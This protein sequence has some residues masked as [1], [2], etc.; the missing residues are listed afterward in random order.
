MNIFVLDTNPSIAAK[1]HCDKHVPKMVLELAQMLTTAHHVY[2]SEPWEGM[3][4]QA[5]L[6]HPCTKWVRENAANYTW[7]AWHFDALAEQYYHRFKKLHKTYLEQ[8]KYLVRR[9]VNM[10]HMEWRPVNMDYMRLCTPFAQAMPDEYKNED[11]A[12][13]AYRTYYLKDKQRFAK[14]ERGV[15]APDWWVQNVV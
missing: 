2:E 5:H 14:W 7:A 4:K 6:N 9:P 8:G 10:E 3:Y 13:T 11:D 15:A 1:M 12:V